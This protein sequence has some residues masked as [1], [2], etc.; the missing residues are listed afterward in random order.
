[1]MLVKLFFSNAVDA[2]GGRERIVLQRIKSCHCKMLLVASWMDAC[3]CYCHCRTPPPTAP[4]FATE[5]EKQERGSIVNTTHIMDQSWIAITFSR[6][7][8]TMSWYSFG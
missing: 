1:M 6:T 8:S 7:F 5:E 3:M 2:D 4:A